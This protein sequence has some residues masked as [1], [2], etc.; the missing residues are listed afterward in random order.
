MGPTHL[1]AQETESSA[2]TTGRMSAIDMAP[3]LFQRWGVPFDFVHSNGDVHSAHSGYFKRHSDCS[4]EIRH[5]KSGHSTYYSHIVPDD[6]QDNVFIESGEHI[7]II[8]L[9]PAT[10]NCKCDWSLRSFLCSTG[11]HVHFE[12]RHNGHP[13][14]LDGKIISNLRIKAGLLPHDSYC[15]DPEDCTS[16]TF[17]GKPCATYYTDMTTGDVICAVTKKE[18]NIGKI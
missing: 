16:A 18:S 15:S 12:I 10:S 2:L 9:D 13:G 11:P 17:E 14:K 4:V 6:I 1:G 5:D 3:Y 8:S 7:G